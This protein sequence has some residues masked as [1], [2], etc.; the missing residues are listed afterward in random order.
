MT[1]PSSS[2]TNWTVSHGSLNSVVTFE[3]FDFPI[4]SQ[5]TSRKPPLLLVPPSSSDFQPCEIKLSFTQ[6]H[7][8]RQV[9]VRS[10]ARVY[11]IYYAA[12]L[13]SD[14]EYLCTVRCSAASL[15]D[16]SFPATDVKEATSVNSDG[17]T[18]VLPKAR[19][20]GENKIGTNEDDWVEV[21]L[22]VGPDQTLNNSRNYQ[23]FYEATAEINDSEPCMSLTIRLLSIQSKGCVYVDE[24]Y[25]FADPI[26]SDDSETQ[27]VSAETSA[28]SSLMTML[29]PTLLGLSKSR[30]VPLHDQTSSNPVGKPI[31]TELEPTTST[32]PVNLV[33]QQDELRKPSE[34][35]AELTQSQ[36]P[37]STPDKDKVFDCTTRNE[38]SN[39]R[40]EILL[41]QLVSRV[42]RIEDICMRFEENMLKPL[43]NIEARLQHVEQQVEL[44]GRR[45]MSPSISRLE[46]DPESISNEGN[47]SKLC[48]EPES[49]NTGFFSSGT[50]KALEDMCMAAVQ[51]FLCDERLEVNGA[52]ESP[53]KEKPTK[54]VSIDD[55]LA[56]ALAGFSSFTKTK[57]SSTVESQEDECLKPDQASIDTTLESDTDGDEVVSV[58]SKS[59]NGTAPEFIGE[60]NDET[61]TYCDEEATE[62]TASLSCPA[63]P[64][65]E[66]DAQQESIKATKMLTF[67][68][69]D[70]L[71]HFP[72][73]PPDASSESRVDFESPI[74][75]VKFASFENGSHKSPLEALWTHS[76]DATRLATDEGGLVE[77]RIENANSLLLDLDGDDVGEE[78]Q[79]DL[80]HVQL[81]TSFPSL[82]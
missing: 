17:S 7:E 41:E 74:L 53:K 35:K 38:F 34:A 66:T 25:V 60:E 43:N 8:I 68:K 33:H 19:V 79:Q 14:N 82:I 46:P 49:E 42:S 36:L 70:I 48:G 22:P 81:E 28:G 12:S 54:T 52:L 45:P 77:E 23:D 71:K 47:N 37:V 2:E 61:T 30:S 55:A 80:P 63:S 62:P 1:T 4:D 11:E 39:N 20:T 51:E 75:E 27:A 72:D 78:V 76:D 58:S 57:D 21:K 65:H 3:S 69:T 13:Q 67:D 18:D 32:N 64:P 9:Y 15:E 10:T 29:V 6:K 5:S 73:Q 31:K 56:A 24:V 50:H 44:L 16:N 26:E 59:L 40:A